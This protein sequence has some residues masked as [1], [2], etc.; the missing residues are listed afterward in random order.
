MKAHRLTQAVPVGI[1]TQVLNKNTTPVNM[2]KTGSRSQ[3]RSVAPGPIYSYCKRKGHVLSEC[4]ALEKKKANNPVMT[5]SKEKQPLLQAK[6]QCQLEGRVMPEVLLEEEHPFVSEG[7]ASLTKEDTQVSVKILRDTGALQSL[8]LQ[9][10]LP[11][12]NKTLMDANVLIQGVELNTITIPLHKV[13]T[14]S[15]LITGPVVVGIRPTLPLK[16]VSFVLGNDLAGGKV[17]PDPWVVE[18]PDQF[19]KTKIDDSVMLPACVVTRAA[20]RKVKYKEMAD[21]E[22][23]NASS[24][25]NQPDHHIKCC[26]SVLTSEPDK[27]SVSDDLSF[28]RKQVIR[29]QELDFEIRCLAEGVVSEEEGA[30]NPKCYYKKGGVLM[31]KWQ[32]PDAPASEEWRVV[33][34]IV[35]P[36]NYREE[37]LS[38]SHGSIMAGHLGINKTYHKILNTS[39]GQG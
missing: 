15:D 8:M 26:D 34:Q 3:R 32:P 22:D 4:W 16:G 12:S 36:P 5:F 20:T 6:Q 27:S 29:D 19:L 24:S 35:V 38:L 21:C 14:H 18:H 1:E 13:C 7:C 2:V 39:T 31:R 25:S 9:N 10:V 28:S 33:H 30:I 17:K 11:L 23:S 37:I